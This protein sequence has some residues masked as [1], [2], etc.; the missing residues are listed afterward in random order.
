MYPAGVPID[1]RPLECQQRAGPAASVKREHKV[2]FERVL[3]L[4]HRSCQYTD[5]G[6][7]LTRMAV[8]FAQLPPTGQGS[9]TEVLRKYAVLKA[10]AIGD[11]QLEAEAA[12]WTDRAIMNMVLAG[13]FPLPLP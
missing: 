7:A 3:K 8:F 2:G 4:G 13:L 9:Q 10:R 1:I 6:A 5:K 12:A 11:K